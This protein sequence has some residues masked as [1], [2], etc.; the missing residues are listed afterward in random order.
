MYRQGDL[1]SY[2]LP[3]LV[4]DSVSVNGLTAN[5]IFKSACLHVL[6]SFVRKRLLAQLDVLTICIACILG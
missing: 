4:R 6:F 2:G 1:L 3:K 5:L